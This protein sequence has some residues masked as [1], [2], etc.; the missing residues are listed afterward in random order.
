MADKKCRT[1]KKMY[2]VFSFNVSLS[3]MAFLKRALPKAGAWPGGLGTSA[4]G[5]QEPALCRTAARSWEAIPSPQG[6][7]GHTGVCRLWDA[8]TQPATLAL[9]WSLLRG[10]PPVPTVLSLGDLL[11]CKE[12]QEEKKTPILPCPAVEP[13]KEATDDSFQV[14]Q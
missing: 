4:P 11:G 2:F 8:S 10:K 9:S 3:I 12:A 14:A 6:H 1:H 5:I 7:R 13:A